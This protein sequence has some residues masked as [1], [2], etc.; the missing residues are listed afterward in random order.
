MDE[1]YICCADALNQQCNGGCYRCPVTGMSLLKTVRVLEMC[2]RARLFKGEAANALE[3]LL[4]EEAGDIDAPTLGSMLVAVLL[5]CRRHCPVL[6][7][8]SGP[9]EA[10]GHLVGFLPP[11]EVSQSTLQK[12]K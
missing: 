3:A 1:V 12:P 6:I 2:D 4:K 5:F 10:A 7:L 11:S 8:A 9:A